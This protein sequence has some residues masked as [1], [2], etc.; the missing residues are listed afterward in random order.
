[1]PC[2]ASAGPIDCCRSLLPA[3]ANSDAVALLPFLITGRGDEAASS[4]ERFAE[5]RLR[6][7]GLDSRAESGQLH[8]VFER[9]RR[10]RGD[11]DPA[12]RLKDTRVLERRDDVDGV[13][14]ANGVA[15]QHVRCRRC[16]PV[17][18]VDVGPGMTMGEA[19]APGTNIS[20]CVGITNPDQKRK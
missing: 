12:H 1:M 16:E 18:P 5:E 7:Y 19:P 9:L 10:Q 6:R 20:S 2:P 15:R 3:F 13:G 17:H 14:S 4:L 11:R 8:Q